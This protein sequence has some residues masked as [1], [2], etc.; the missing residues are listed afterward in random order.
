MCSTGESGQG[1]RP[2][3]A[4]VECDFIRRTKHIQ[5]TTRSISAKHFTDGAVSVCRYTRHLRSLIDP[6][7]YSSALLTPE[8]S[9]IGGTYL[10][11]PYWIGEVETDLI[12]V[13]LDDY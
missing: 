13:K 9:H 1:C 4:F 3:P 6:Y 10:E 7:C 12:V 2:L 5:G 11:L 8:L